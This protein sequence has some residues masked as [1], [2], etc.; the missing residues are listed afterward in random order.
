MSVPTSG[1]PVKTLPRN[2]DK[3]VGQVSPDVREVTVQHGTKP[4]DVILGVALIANRNVTGEHEV[5][6]NAH[7]EHIRERGWAGGQR[8]QMLR[9]DETVRAGM[10]CNGDRRKE[11]VSGVSRVHD[12]V[13]P[14][15]ASTDV[16]RAEVSVN[17]ATIVKLR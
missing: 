15:A 2:G 1:L 4:T 8:A 11:F 12:D 10:T 17:D 3:F 6:Q 16:V 14:V 7:A 13:G 5:D 9:A